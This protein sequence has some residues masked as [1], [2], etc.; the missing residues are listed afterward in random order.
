M[1]KTNKMKVILVLLFIALSI[2]A[3][4]VVKP[5]QEPIKSSVLD[6]NFFKRELQESVLEFVND[7]GM[8]PDSAYIPF[9]DELPITF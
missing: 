7:M 2:N 6:E 4:D 1:R 3:A 9:R 5:V 8:D